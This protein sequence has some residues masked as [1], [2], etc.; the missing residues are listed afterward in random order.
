MGFRKFSKASRLVPAAL[1]CGSLA[2][3]ALVPA[4]GVAGLLLTFLVLVARFD[5][6]SGT[7][8]PLAVLGVIV[9]AVMAFLIAGLA[10]VHALMSGAS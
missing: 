10:L 4:L 7:Y 6:G 8:L 3:L 2:F 1:L 9:L 5:D